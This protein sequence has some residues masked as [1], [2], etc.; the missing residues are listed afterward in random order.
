VS[1]G[2]PTAVASLAAALRDEVLSG[3]LAPGLPLREERIA[4][5]FGVSRHTVR[6]ALAALAAERLLTAEP[7]R[8]VRV[9]AF[10]DVQLVELQQLRT[11]LEG[12]AV[13]IA[14]ERGSLERPPI[15]A[16]IARLAEVERAGRDWLQVERAHAAVHQALVDAAG[17]RRLSATHRTL[18]GELALLL[19]HT[20]TT[21]A[22]R[23]LAA[24]HRALLVRIEAEGPDAVREHIAESTRA[25][26]LARGG[27]G[28][29]GSEA[30]AGRRASAPSSGS[31]SVAPPVD[32]ARRAP[33]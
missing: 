12:E 29:A 11:A 20:R 17:S 15:E 14:L 10:D 16:A 31:P 13:R 1:V 9:S 21:F 5:R 33:R 3:R 24:D 4:E 6:S 19:L 8:G 2:A 23:D 25:L 22:E 7:Y 27:T 26:L 28:A 18:E 30:G 32:P